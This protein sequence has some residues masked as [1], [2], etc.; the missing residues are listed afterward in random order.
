MATRPAHELLYDSEASLRL[1]DNAI[2]ELGG[3]GEIVTANE[4]S[5]LPASLVRAYGDITGILARLR[6]SR[7]TLEQGAMAKLKHMQEKLTEVSRASETA[8]N[9][10]L[11]GLERAAL[12]VDE[13]D[14]LA[15]DPAGAS[16]GAELRGAMREEIL[17]LVMHL[18]FQDITAQQLAYV[19]SV[20]VEIEQGFAQMGAIFDPRALG[21]EAV[22]AAA[23][24]AA[25]AGL[26]ECSIPTRRRR[27]RRTVRPWRT[28]SS[29]NGQSAR[30]AAPSRVSA[31]LPAS[32]GRH[33]PT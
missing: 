21:L 22:A 31:Q 19:S 6:E 24:S 5:A 10:L 26:A 13:L 32:C 17:G 18:Q 23:P 15:E 29:V 1:V 8:A 30:R 28:R 33:Y 20:I 3:D 25:N 4:S 7:G 11:D 14:A 27:I 2:G 16:R 12:M 9:Q